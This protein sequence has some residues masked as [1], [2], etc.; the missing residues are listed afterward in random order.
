MKSMYL[1]VIE[2]TGMPA[3]ELPSGVY[4]DKPAQHIYCK[5]SGMPAFYI[6]PFNSFKAIGE[7]KDKSAE[8]TAITEDGLLKAI[9]IALK[10]ELGANLFK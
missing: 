6:G 2:T 1:E 8:S 10:P 5:A 7:I 3:Q 4:L 9:A